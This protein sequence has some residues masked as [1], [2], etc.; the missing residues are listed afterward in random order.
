[1]RRLRRAEVTGTG[2]TGRKLALPWRSCSSRA[3]FFSL[4]TVSYKALCTFWNRSGS[5]HGAACSEA[6]RRRN[7]AS[8]SRAG[9]R[10]LAVRRVSHCHL[11]LA[12]KRSAQ[13]LFM[14]IAALPEVSEAKPNRMSGNAVLC[15]ATTAEPGARQGASTKQS[16]LA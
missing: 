6:E 14:H 9:G 13:T 16:M 4:L 15:H 1:V 11:W 3:L 10:K 7:E 12:G 2:S 5:I 8:S